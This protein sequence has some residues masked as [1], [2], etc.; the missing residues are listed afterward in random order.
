MTTTDATTAG[1]GREV[2]G[3]TPIEAMEAELAGGIQ[4]HLDEAGFDEAVAIATESVG[5][6]TLFSLPA[7]GLVEKAERIAAVW[8]GNETDEAI[9]FVVLDED[10]SAVRIERGDGAMEDMSK[11]VHSYVDVLGQLQHLE[12]TEAEAA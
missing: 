3:I 10:G 1:E 7:A 9:V 12:F 6:R 8:L 4:D 5:A 2:E 11:L